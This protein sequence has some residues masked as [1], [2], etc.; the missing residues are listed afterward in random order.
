MSYDSDEQFTQISGTGTPIVELS[1]DAATQV[2]ADG[3]SVAEQLTAAQAVHD[4]FLQHRRPD[5]EEYIGA[6]DTPGRP[7]IITAT[8]GG[9]VRIFTADDMDS[10][11]ECCEHISCPHAPGCSLDPINQ[12]D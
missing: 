2:A 9:L 3:L 12:E 11:P 10:C 4:D 7:L 1:S 8:T 5:E 6:I